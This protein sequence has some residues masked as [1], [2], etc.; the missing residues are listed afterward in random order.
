MFVRI[1]SSSAVP[2]Y[3][4]I[5]DQIKYQIA[6][7]SL[8]PHDRLPSV[9]ELSRQLPVNQNTIVKVYDLLA[10]EG[11]ISRRQ[12]DGTYVAEVP[13]TLKKSER[14]RQ[15]SAL[16]GRAAAQAVHF[17]I[18]PDELHTL[19]DKEIQTLAKGERTNA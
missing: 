11:V 4:Q 14:M 16:L 9:R 19:L 18:S 10:A 17:A 6:N 12:G 13:P 7:G 5:V 3:R 1:E 15:V 2:V 8:R